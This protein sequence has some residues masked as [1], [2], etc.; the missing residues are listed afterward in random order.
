MAVEDIRVSYH[1]S[2]KNIGILITDHNVHESAVDNRQGLS[3]FRRE[4]LKV[5]TA[6]N[7]PR[8]S[9]SEKFTWGKTSSSEDKYGVENRQQLVRIGKWSLNIQQFYV[10]LPLSRMC[11]NW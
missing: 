9:M 6:V 3:L 4:N 10:I 2:N 5:G 8:M 7:L 1:N 11:R